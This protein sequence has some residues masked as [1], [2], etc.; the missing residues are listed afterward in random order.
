KT[1]DREI[2]NP[3][4]E[5]IESSIRG[6]DGRCCSLVMLFTDQASNLSIAGGNDERFVV[7]VTHGINGPYTSL[8]DADPDSSKPVAEVDVVVGGQEVPYPENRVV[9]LNKALVA[10]KYWAKYGKEDPSML[11]SVPGS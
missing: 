2:L 6:L 9:G 1:H 4:L 5:E 7:D 11:W 3:S 8:L 10:A